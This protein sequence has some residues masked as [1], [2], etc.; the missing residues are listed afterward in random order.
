M[1]KVKL[2][3][4]RLHRAFK[5]K[6][7]MFVYASTAHQNVYDD[8][9]LSVTSTRGDDSREAGASINSFEVNLEGDYRRVVGARSH[10]ALT[11]EGAAIVAAA[12]GNVTPAQIAQRNRGRTGIVKVRDTGRLCT[13]SIINS[14]FTALLKRSLYNP[15]VITGNKTG[16]VISRTAA[17]PN[18]ADSVTARSVGVFDSV[19]TPPELATFNNLVKDFAEPAGL[20]VREIPAATAVIETRTIQAR[21]D[22]AINRA[23]TAPHLTRGAGLAPAD[24][25]QDNEFLGT[26]YKLTYTKTDGSTESILTSNDAVDRTFYEIKE[27]DLTQ[28]RK[29]TSQINQHAAALEAAAT[30][31]G[32]RP[33]SLTV[34]L[35][36]LLTSKYKHQRLQA[37]YLLTL[38]AGDP[39]FFSMDW[40]EMAGVWFAQQIKESVTGAAWRLELSLYPAAHIVG[41]SLIEH[42]PAPQTWGAARMSWANANKNWG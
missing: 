19:Q 10:F 40:E 7:S 3:D 35:I 16:A 11:D 29:E 8:Q 30:Y 13:S 15:P 5:P 2:K 9:I 25:A 17:V 20:Q 26:L 21:I 31:T 4:S 27:V 6:R 1:P 28:I 12:A 39:V 38:Q 36:Q 32:S 14:G 42:L 22:D 37:G 23:K 33:Q 18:L 41:R 34:D 24:F